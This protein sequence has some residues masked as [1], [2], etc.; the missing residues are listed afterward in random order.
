MHRAITALVTLLVLSS[1]PKIALAALIVTTPGDDSVLEAILGFENFDVPKVI[2]KIKPD[3]IAVGFDQSNLEN[4]LVTY[5]KEK[6]LNVKIVKI[7]KFKEDE[8][9]SSSKIKQKIIK[10]FKR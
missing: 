3:V 2:Q 1:T 6:N 4:I 9:D 10:D 5:V 8:L 7:G